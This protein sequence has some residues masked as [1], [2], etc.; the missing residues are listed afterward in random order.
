[1]PLSSLNN[2]QKGATVNIPISLEKMIN[3]LE[4]Y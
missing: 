2:P 1:M 3:A 4:I